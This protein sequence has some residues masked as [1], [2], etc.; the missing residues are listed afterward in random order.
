MGTVEHIHIAS[1]AAK[2]MVA[3]AEAEMIMGK[4][5]EGDRYANK[6]GYYSDHPAPGRH[7]TII[8]IEVLEE[9]AQSLGIA[10]LPH[11]S[12]RN[13]TTRGIR[14]NPLVGKNV[15]IGSV[16]LDVIRFCD[17]CAYLQTM[18]GKPVLKSLTDRAGLRC[19]VITGGTIRV[20]D[21]I[22]VVE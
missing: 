8:E 6:I 13:L 12:R 16:V 5:I 4:G 11:E 7:V 14:L 3:L 20:G 18:L 15:Q 2:P 17:P 22:T 10:F 19:D 1:E 21:L 9:I